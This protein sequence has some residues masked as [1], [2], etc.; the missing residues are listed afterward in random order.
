[1]RISDW[2]SDVCSSD[3]FTQSQGLAVLLAIAFLLLMFAV[4]GIYSDGLAGNAE[5]AKL[6]RA[7]LLPFVPAMALQIPMFVLSAALRGVGDVRTASIAQRSEERRVGKECV[8]TC[9]SRWSPIHSKNI[10][11]RR[12]SESHT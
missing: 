9:R 12:P 2:S 10:Q 5:V 1:M 3:L 8:I 6:T 4:R 11:I 7:F